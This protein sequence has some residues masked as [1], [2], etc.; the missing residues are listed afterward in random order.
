[1]EA[2]FASKSLRFSAFVTGGYTHL[3]CSYQQVTLA[4]G[5]KLDF[6]RPQNFWPNVLL[7]WGSRGAHA[8][9]L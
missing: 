2:A 6:V 7:L 8:G 4:K 3:C 5:A 1:M 9:G